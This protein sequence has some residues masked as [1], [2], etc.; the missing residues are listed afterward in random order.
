M[1]ATV[2]GMPFKEVGC[3]TPLLAVART[4]TYQAAL[5]FQKYGALAFKY[6]NGSRL[7]PLATVTHALDNL[8]RHT[9]T[10]WALAQVHRWRHCTT[11]RSGVRLIQIL[12]QVT[13]RAALCYGCHVA[14]PGLAQAPHVWVSSMSIPSLS[15]QLCFCS[16]SHQHVRSARC[17]AC[18]GRTL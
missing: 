13:T 2:P 3:S 5:W 14:V 1:L 12:H 18:S 9:A 8:M 11:L 17:D 6:S 4:R 7:R 10:K 15:H 16:S